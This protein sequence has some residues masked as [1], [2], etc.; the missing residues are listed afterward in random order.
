VDFA[1]K[2]GGT[3]VRKIKLLDS[4]AAQLKADYWIWNVV[5]IS[6][7]DTPTRLPPILYG[8]LNEKVL[9][10]WLKL[11]DGS[12]K[13]M[14]EIGP[15]SKRLAEGQ[16]FTVTR[17]ELVSDNEWSKHPTVERFKRDCG[18]NDFLFSAWP[19]NN[20]RYGVIRF[21]R[22]IEQLPFEKKN[23]LFC[24]AVM[25]QSK[26]VHETN[27][28]ETTARRV[29]GLPPRLRSTLFLLLLGK[30]RSEIAHELSISID[31]A[32]DHVKNIF[33]R[34]AV[35]SHVDL[36]CEM[37]TNPHQLERLFDGCCSCQVEAA[38]SF[39]RGDQKS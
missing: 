8:G 18:L 24:R 25:E 9:I 7:E 16:P 38:K 31:A 10:N 39:S 20:Q 23:Q 5:D 12:H 13:P 29:R 3:N 35:N 19:I 33:R 14:P 17:S 22:S 28:P 6:S 37:T 2:H 1:S 21:F 32:K 27:V 34:V 4:L 30:R 26:W 11:T 15:L 36:I